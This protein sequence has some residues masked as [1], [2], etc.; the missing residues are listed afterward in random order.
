MLALTTV[1]LFVYGMVG[2]VLFGDDLPERWGNIG[3]AML[4][5][6]VLLTLENFPIYL[7][8]GMEVHPWAW[9][10]FIS[11]ALL[12]AFVLLNVLIGI[13]LNSMEEARELERRRRFSVEGRPGDG[14]APAPVL[15]RIQILRAALK[16]LE[17]ELALHPETR[18][19]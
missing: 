17:D 15:E 9:V 16:E 19:E 7:E 13:V 8:E 18:A 5:L 1:M 10:Y 14:V 4:T 6:V 2:W 11:F 12:T 3:A